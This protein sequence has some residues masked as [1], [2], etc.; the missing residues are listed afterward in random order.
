MVGAVRD[1]PV[2]SIHLDG[3]IL[4]VKTNACQKR[5]KKFNMILKA[6]TNMHAKSDIR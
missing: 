2:F 4:E 1:T 5:H 3:S 6:E